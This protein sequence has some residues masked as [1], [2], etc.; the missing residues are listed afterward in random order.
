MIHQQQPLNSP[1]PFYA[2][3]HSTSPPIYQTYSS[4]H[5][6]YSYSPTPSHHSIYGHM[7]IPPVIYGH[8]PGGQHQPVVYIA[9]PTAH[10]PVVNSPANV[11]YVSNAPP[12]NVV[13]HP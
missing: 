5:T 13:N 7:P 6:H 8:S 12:F 4:P 10:P 2:T 1:V 11:V 9:A 3:S